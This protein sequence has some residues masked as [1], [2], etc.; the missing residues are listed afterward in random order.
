MVSPD[1]QFCT[2]NSDLLR[3]LKGIIQSIGGD[4]GLVKYITGTLAIEQKT[5]S[6][7]VPNPHYNQ[8]MFSVAAVKFSTIRFQ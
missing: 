1:H 5:K 7:F 6:L 2:Q 4:Q 3:L 8:L